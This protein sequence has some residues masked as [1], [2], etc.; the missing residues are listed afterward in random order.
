MTF[1]RIFGA[2]AVVLSLAACGDNSPRL[3]ED[4]GGNS[5]NSWPLF[6]G[7]PSGRANQSVIV[8]GEFVGTDEVHFARGANADG[9]YH[10]EYYC[11]NPLDCPPTPQP[12]PVED[13]D[14]YRHATWGAFGADRAAHNGDY[15]LPTDTNRWPDFTADIAFVRLEADD[16]DLYVH[17][18][19][20]SFP[21][22]NTQIA[23]FAF[24]NAGTTPTVNAWPRNAGI[25]SAHSHAFTLWGD[26][27]EVAEVGGVSS[28]L[29]SLGGEVRTSGHA[30]E[31]RIPL[32]ALP[33]APWRLNVGAGLADPNDHRQYWTVPAGS[34]TATAPGTDANNAPGSNV[35]DLAFTPHDPN[36]HDD[37][38]QADLLLAG[39][40]SDAHAIVN[41]AAMQSQASTVAP[42]ITGRINHTYQSAFDFGDGITRGPGAI[43]PPPNLGPAAGL[44]PNTVKPRDTAVSYEYT[45]A[46]QPYLAYIPTAYPSSSHDWPLVLYFHGLNNYAWEPFGLT[47]GLEDELEARGYLFASL[48]GRGDIFFEGRGELDP[49][50]V[51]EHMSA[52]YR[53]DKNRIYILGHS[54]GGGGVINVSSRNPDLFAGVASTQIINGPAR[55]E[56][57]LHLPTM[58][59]AGLGDPIDTGNGAN[60]RY[61]AGA[62]L[63][64]DT[65]SIV[66]T[67]KTHENSAIYDSLTQIFDMFDR[68]TNP[69]NP[70]EVIYTRSGG[71][72][73]VS[74]GL[75]HNGA[76]W[77]SNMQAANDAADMTI[78]AQSFGIAHQPLDPSNATTTQNNAFDSGGINSPLR[79]LGTHNQSIPAYGPAITVSNRVDIGTT[80]L[81]AATFDIARMQID[82]QAPDAVFNLNLSHDLNLQLSNAGVSSLNWQAEDGSGATIS[83][84]T[85]T[86][87]NNTVDIA[88][89]AT[90]AV[91]RF[92]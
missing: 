72:F 30:L 24:S 2:T 33:A 71:D 69:E 61:Q 88:V 82:L 47:L 56:N 55:P 75:L 89:P 21:A 57:Y 50:E 11:L 90:T 59:I 77:V 79:T 41:L 1:T 52:R 27:G 12:S 36:Y 18:R 9:I 63:G 7:M 19:F 65:Q 87:T 8:D 22:A 84:G 81:A 13:D 92:P 86:L 78:R 3:G 67:L 14:V 60:S 80:N 66:Y 25:G 91:L 15:L 16:S 70:G 42:A 51:I 54:H 37:H 6:D 68:H 44:I 29:I 46:M 40:V 17:I 53:I 83:S 74:L 45:G 76:Y 85:A 4:N 26:G 73:D 64:Y 49:L 31:A 23:T 62:D 5:A 43:P 20:V 10:E 48:L 28:D 34:P 35:W 58:H 38:I 39:D 32:S